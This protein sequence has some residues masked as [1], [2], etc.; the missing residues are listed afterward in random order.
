MNS[1]NYKLV[2]DLLNSDINLPTISPEIISLDNNI[3]IYLFENQNLNIVKIEFFFQNA[4]AINQNKLFTSAIT[5]NQ[6]TEGSNNYSSRE[7]AD[8]IDYYG[9]FIDKYVDKES[10]SVCFYFLSKYQDNII[11]WIEEIIKNPV[12]PEKELEILRPKLKQQF[13]V[14]NQRTDFLARNKFNES[15]FGEDNPYGK[16]GKLEDF[17]KLERNDLIGFYNKFYNFRE[18]SIILSGS[19]NPKLISSLNTRFGKDNWNAS[20]VLDDK[21]NTINFDFHSPKKET[22]Y[23]KQSVQSSICIGK[24]TISINHEDYFGLKI[25][26]TLLG[27]YFGSR[28]MS[29][30]REDK[31]YTYGI[32]SVIHSFTD[33]GLFLVIGDV[34]SNH[35]Q[36]AIDE[37]YK[38]INRLSNQ[39]VSEEELN[40]VKNHLIGSLIRSLDGCLEL[41]E[42]FRNIL[43]YNLDYLYFE[44]YIQE[45][46]K[47]QPETI[48]DLSN[49]YFQLESL[50][51]I[52]VGNET[53][54][55]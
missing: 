20:E 21:I 55:L 14:N 12:F 38:E 28:L 53:L 2:K 8:A 17:D 19:S 44:N 6:I 46:K 32:G 30:I 45:I 50:T 49:K 41:G 10:S 52:R 24:P 29:N 7:I 51:E 33:I 34:K 4:G 27:G 22:I 36:N 42:R 5:N 1:K 47:M 43:K 16:I 35:T 39:L 37:I 18:C 9:A 40:M 54:M 3:K 26:N 25:V 48:K 15:V 23:L 13:L 11:S 31:G